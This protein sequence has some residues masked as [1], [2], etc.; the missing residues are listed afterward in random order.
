[1]YIA[2]SC[3]PR[4]L[5]LFPSLQ[6]VGTLLVY[7]VMDGAE[8]SRGQYCQHSGAQEA[9]PQTYNGLE[10]CEREDREA[11]LW[12]SVV[13]DSVR[14]KLPSEPYSHAGGDDVDNVA[15]NLSDRVKFENNGIFQVETK[16]DCQRR[17]E[18][19]PD[20]GCQDGVG[21]KDSGHSV[22]FAG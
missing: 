22:D 13:P 10:E 9:K 11:E 21:N 15:E 3:S 6:V 8:L 2:R 17:Y 14:L 18:Q 12:M 20:H 16:Q 19:D 7:G 1:M 5:G 4:R